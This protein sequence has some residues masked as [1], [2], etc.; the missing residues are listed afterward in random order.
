MAG[1][2]AKDEANRTY[3]TYFRAAIA[4]NLFAEAEPVAERVLRSKETAS[5]VILLADLVKIMA[6][7]GRGCLRGVPGQPHLG[8]R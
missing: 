3:E 4:A 6:E 8:A 1:K 7:V 2:Q 5:S